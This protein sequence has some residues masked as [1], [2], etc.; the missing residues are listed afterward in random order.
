MR[1]LTIH[2]VAN[3]LQ[4]GTAHRPLVHVKGVRFLVEPDQQHVAADVEDRVDS[5]RDQGERHRRDCRVHCSGERASATKGAC[6]GVMPTLEDAQAEVSEK[7][8][9]DG[10]LDLDNA[11]MSRLWRTR[12]GTVQL[13]AH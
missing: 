9:P 3:R 5:R 7:T 13:A 11:E 8:G 6:S 10:N 12:S 1:L 4:A 2:N